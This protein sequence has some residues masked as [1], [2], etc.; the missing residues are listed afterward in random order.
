MFE[1]IS[2]CNSTGFSWNSCRIKKVSI[3]VITLTCVSQQAIAANSY[4]VDEPLVIVNGDV[5]AALDVA[6][7]VLSGEVHV[8]GQ[9]HFYMETHGCIAVPAC[10]DGEMV[11]I[12]ATQDTAHVQVKRGTASRHSFVIKYEHLVATVAE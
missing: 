12:S 11:V 7:Y 2:V 1:S 8:G 5:C 9:E 3:L 10:E 6:D 4:L